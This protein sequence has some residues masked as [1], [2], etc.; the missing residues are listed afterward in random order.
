MRKVIVVPDLLEAYRL[1]KRLR[2]YVKREGDGYAVYA[3]APEEIVKE[4]L[5][6]LS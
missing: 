2:G 3:D 6:E 5:K 4:A 1:A